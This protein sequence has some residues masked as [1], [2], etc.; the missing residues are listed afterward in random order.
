MQNTRNWGLKEGNST[1]SCNKAH[2]GS[3]EGIGS[4]A[5]AA[6][7]S[8]TLGASLPPPPLGFFQL[9]GQGVAFNNISI[10]DW[11]LMR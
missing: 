5:A 9:Q 1:A 2:Q 8:V 6:T 11:G 10:S 7:E 3:G 4:M